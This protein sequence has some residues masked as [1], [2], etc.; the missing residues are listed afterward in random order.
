MQKTM[1]CRACAILLLAAT[2]LGVLL[3]LL[4]LRVGATASSYSDVLDDLRLDSTFDESL[5]PARSYVEYI[6]L[7]YDLDPFNDKDIKLLSVIQ[8]AE[9]ED[10]ELFVYTYQPLNA[11][12]DITAS[13]VILYTGD[14]REEEELKKPLERVS[15]N[16][17]F[18]KYVVKD[19]ALPSDTYRYYNIVEI[20]RPWSEL[21][22]D[23]ISDITITQYAAHDVGQTWC[24]YYKN[25]KLVYEMTKL[26][27]VQITPT[28]TDFVYFKDG[29]TWGTLLGRETGCYAHYI[30]FNIENYSVDEIYDATLEYYYRSVTMTR[31]EKHGFAAIW[32]VLFGNGDEIKTEYPNGENWEVESDCDL[33]SSDKVTYEGVGLLSKTYKWNRIMTST[34]FLDKLVDQGVEFGKEEENTLKSSQ[35]VFAFT[36]TD[37]VSQE[38]ILDDGLSTTG[39]ESFAT[40]IN[41]TEIS[42]VDILRLHFR[43]GQK[44][45]DLGVVSDTTRGDLEPGGVGDPTKDP[46][47]LRW[48]FQVL[49]LVLVV[50]VLTFLWGPISLVLKIFC[51]GLWIGLKVFL[52]LLSLPF[53]L[54]GRLLK[55]KR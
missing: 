29:V 28:L 47:W 15:S 37:V 6:S 54:I 41:T 39:G 38:Y 50:L 53:K 30:A 14:V 17:V 3:C 48:I 25:D 22:D 8:I 55:R 31:V 44:I 45:Y 51:S 36:E 11:D 1:K 40:V 42:D 16:G 18:N 52:W 27:V 12:V 10:G 32:D 34:A 35:Y 7:K 49:F 19:F 9:G 20:E 4:P 23:K 26:R 13:S 24:C 2:L 5:Y 33:Y 43:V 21:L 46:D